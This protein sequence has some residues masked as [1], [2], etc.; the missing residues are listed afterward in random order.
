MKKIF[1]YLVIL[2][3]SLFALKA[4]FHP[5]IFTA[6]DIWHQVARIYRY[7]HALDDGQFPPY[8][9]SDLANRLGYPLFFFS[10]HLPWII[11]YPLLKVGLDIT[12]TIKTL[13]VISYL[14]SGVSM[15]FF[16]KK[17]FS[18]KIT[19]LLSA[20]IYLWSPFRFLT[21]L[22]S[23]AIGTNFVFV[24]LPLIFLGI[25]K[26]ANDKRKSG[27]I[28]ICSTSIAGT[29][30]SHLMSFPAIAPSLIIFIIWLLLNIENKPKF[31]KNL[32]LSGILGIGACAFYLL[33]AIYYSKFTQVSSGAF[34]TLYQ[35]NFLSLSQ[36]IYSKW[37]YGLIR[38]TAKE[39][40]FSYQIGISEWLSF[41]TTII[42]IG[43]RK[44]KTLRCFLDKKYNLSLPFVFLLSFLISILL[45]LDLSKPVWDLISRFITLDFPAMFIIPATF[46]GSLLAGIVFLQLNK[47]I[48]YIFLVGILL[49]MFY[50]NRNYLRVNMYIY[51]PLEGFIASEITTNSFHEYLPRTAD[52]ELLYQN[53]P[54][55]YPETVVASNI[56]QNTKGLSL[57]AL[58]PSNA[59]VSVRQFAFPGIVLYVDYQK[60]DYLTDS[61]G[62]VSFLLPKGEHRI[63]VIF[64]ETSLI[65]LSKTLTI[66]AVILLLFLFRQSWIHK[67]RNEKN[68]KT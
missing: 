67:N 13:F 4:L 50:T 24:F 41:T 54:F 52:I 44:L 47:S 17:L 29:I 37:G 61:S 19:A 65:K 3:L 20:I 57:S 36:L 33:P 28:A 23:A 5:G 2:I 49:I 43:I 38:T 22:V 25:Y 7:S 58:S 42:L 11:G 12:A 48:R 14:L 9:I 56:Q 46:S 45:M 39:A 30:L 55:V 15:Y 27:G 26:I 60:T 16:A 34:S 63:E 31:I 68:K 51:E 62:R 40:E 53:V 32:F 10:Y 59:M 21:I 1:P 66:T 6:H 8:W 18:N 64:E 35:K